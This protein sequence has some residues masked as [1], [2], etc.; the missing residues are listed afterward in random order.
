MAMTP[1]GWA[2]A[3]G[4]GGSAADLA[5][6]P[7]IWV[8]EGG[9]SRTAGSVR[10]QWTSP[11]TASP[12]ARWAGQPGTR[13]RSCS[14][15][16]MVGRPPQISRNGHETAA[17][18]TQDAAAGHRRPAHRTPVGSRAE[19]QRPQ[20]P[21]NQAVRAGVGWCGMGGSPSRPPLALAAAATLARKVP[22][23]QRPDSASR[24]EACRAQA[25]Q[26]F[27][28]KESWWDYATL[29]HLA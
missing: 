7:L 9:R 6:A 28:S 20:R 29:I 8:L 24:P 19:L 2:R 22:C 10:A 18:A 13:C 17:Q 23:K 3:R 21:N 25:P 1:L 27:T 12:N 11:F 14:G 16:L 4:W 26:S 5:V 15:A